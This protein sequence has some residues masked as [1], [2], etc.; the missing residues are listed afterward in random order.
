MLVAADRRRSA[1]PTFCS[2]WA[3]E[4]VPGIG[5]TTGEQRRSQASDTCGSGQRDL[6]GEG[7]LLVPSAFVWPSVVSST[8]PPWQPSFSQP[9][10]LHLTEHVLADRAAIS[11]RCRV[12][13]AS[14][15]A[16]TSGNRQVACA[17]PR[18]ETPTSTADLAALTDLTPGG[19]SQH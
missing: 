4:D 18:L 17:N 13:M 15:Q 3:V 9:P 14:K 8:I 10:L 11:P 12:H 5:A 1:V 16:S 6:G 2:R 19:V 7:L